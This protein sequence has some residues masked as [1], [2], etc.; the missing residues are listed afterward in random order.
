MAISYS[1]QEG[2]KVPGFKRRLM[3]SWLKSVAAM[4]GR[5]II[6]VAYQFCDNPRILEFN[7]KFLGHNYY[8]DIITFDNSQSDEGIIADILIS[9]DEVALNGEEYGT[10]FRDELL[11]V[12]VHG[13]LHLSGFDDHTEEESLEMR[14][15][16]DEALAL[17]PEGIF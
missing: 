16:E 2:V 1:S 11:R 14:R 17:V 5:E 3:G 10:G 13:I 12:M 8:T 7:K 4:H 9:V 6:D 15:A